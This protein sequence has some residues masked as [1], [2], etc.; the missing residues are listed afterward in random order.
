MFGEVFD[1][2]AAG[3]AIFAALVLTA[4][5]AFFLLF[6]AKVIHCCFCVW[7]CGGSLSRCGV[8]VAAAVVFCELIFSVR[9]L[10]VFQRESYQESVKGYICQFMSAWSIVIQDSGFLQPLQSLI[11]TFYLFSFYNWHYKW[12]D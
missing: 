5:K 7:G 2:T 6:F 9:G 12:R 4:V 8:S 11:L 1:F 10:R 3:T